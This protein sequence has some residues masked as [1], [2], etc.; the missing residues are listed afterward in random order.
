MLKTLMEKV[1]TLRSVGNFSQEM[2]SKRKKSNGILR[3][4]NPHSKIN[5]ENLQHV[6]QQIYHWLYNQ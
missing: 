6:Y 2:G 4:K 3:N 1:K 5:E